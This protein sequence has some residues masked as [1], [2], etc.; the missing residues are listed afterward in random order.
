MK[1]MTSKFHDILLTDQCNSHF[2]EKQLLY[3]IFY[4]LV[5]FKREV[6]FSPPV[7]NPFSANVPFTP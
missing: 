6:L 2:H 5:A 1:S 4:Y 7:I 3:R